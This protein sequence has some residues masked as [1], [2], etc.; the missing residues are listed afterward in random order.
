MVG[1]AVPSLGLFGR[2]GPDF[3][4]NMGELANALKYI[5][6]A[7][8][9]VFFSARTT[10]PPEL[11]R[12]FASSNTPVFVVN[13]QNWIE[14]GGV[15]QKYLWTEHPLKEFAEASGGRYFSDVTAVEAVSASIQSFSANYYV[16]GYYVNEAWDG[17]FHQ[18][19]VE[20]TRPGAKV[21]AQAGYN[22]PRP[23]AE[24]SEI[25]K[26]L[27]LYDLAFA[28]RPAAPYALDIPSAVLSCPGAGGTTAVALTALTV[29]EKTGVPPGKA[30]V[31]AIVFEK[32]G[33]A[34]R[35][36]RATTDLTKSAG[37]TPCFYV[38][39]PLQA[40]DYEVR[41]VARDLETGQAAVGSAALTVPAGA[42]AGLR[43]SSPLLIVPGREPHYLKLNWPGRGRGQIDARGF[44]SVPSEKR[45]PARRPAPRRRED[46]P[47]GP[48][49]RV[50]GRGG[51]AES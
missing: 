27:N 19:R 32:G 50:P 10:I 2:R 31:L 15:K 51:R 39:S 21:Y 20:T 48:G 12:A 11:G 17:R 22:N 40:G 14:R 33:L 4:E 47:G 9:I 1:S 35:A 28:D 23:F 30:E 41:F 8:T 49:G 46:D 43:F 7:K 34:V 25:E 5:P 6:G 26:K 3:I 42:E 29:D 13:T 36:L 18:I 37:Q 24:W 45:Q 16:L 44:L 38:A